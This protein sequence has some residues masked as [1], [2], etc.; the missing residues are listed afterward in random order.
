MALEYKIIKT[1]EQYFSYCESLKELLT[2]DVNQKLDE[3]ELLT[4]LIEKWDSENISIPQLDPIQLIK[5]LML[6]HNINSSKLSKI[7][8][9]SKGT[10]SKMLNYHKGL[11]KET[12]RK[13]SKYFAI[14]QES[15]NRT[16]VLKSPVNRNFRNASL[17]N[18]KKEMRET[19]NPS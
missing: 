17:M 19:L 4:L 11:S 15:L 10:I 8:N 16:Y 12:I 13:V 14:N 3:I 9:L 1:E 7:L 6:E 5:S 2:I 18:T